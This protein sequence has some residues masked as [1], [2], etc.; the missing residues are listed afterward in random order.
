DRNGEFN[1][2]S[3]ATATKKITQLTKFEDFPII[4]STHGNGNIIFEQAGYLHTFGPAAASSKKLTI[5]IAADL[6]EL[7]PRYLEGSKYIRSADISPSG[8]RVVFD[9]RG[10]IMTVPAEKGDA[11]NLTLTTGTHEKYPAWSADG[12]SI[13][14]FS[15]ATGEYRLHVEAQDGKGEMETYD[16]AGNG[17]YAAIRWS[18]NGKKISY[19]DN[20][21]NL[22]LLDIKSG[23]IAKVD[24]DDLYIPGPFRN[25]FGDWSPDSKWIVYTKITVTN[26][27][28]I[29]LYSLEQAKSFPLTDG[30]SNASDPIFDPNG[31]YIYFLASTDAGPVVDWFAQSNKDMEMNSSIYLVTLTKDLLSPFAKESDEEGD[32]DEDEDDE[33]KGKGEKVK[34]VEPTKIDIDGI[35]NRIIDIPLKAG[36]YSTLGINKKRQLLY[37]VQAKKGDPGKLHKYDLKKRKDSEVMPLDFYIIAKGG[38]KMLYRKKDT[39]GITEAGEKPEDGKGVLKTKELKIKIEPLAEW[40][41]IYDEAWRINRDYFY[42][43]G[44]HGADWKA[45]KAKYSVFLPDLTCRRDLSKL[46]QWMCSE[47]GVGHHRTWGGERVNDAPK[48]SGGLLGT[49][50]KITSGRYQFSKIYGG[51]NWTPNLR[52]P[53]TEPGI[54]AEDGDYLLAV[55]GVDV[56]ADKN[57]YSY[58]ENTAGKIVELTIGARPDCTGSRVV[59]VVPTEYEDAL[60]NRDWVEGNMR[61]VHEATDGQVAYVYVPNT[62]GAGHQYFKRYFFPQQDKKAIIIDE[63]FNGGGLLA[64]YYIDI[65]LR[66]YQSYWNFRYGQDVKTPTASIQGPKVMIIDETAGSG[67]D[68]LPYMF[69]KFE[70]GTLVG[71][72]TWGGLV[73]ILG[74]PLF[75][76]GGSVTAPNVAIWT[77]DGYIVENVGVPPDI[78]VDQTPSEVIKGK[79]PQLEKAIEI[80]LKQ[81]KENPQTKPK[82]PNYPIRGNR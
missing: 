46:I 81:L 66:P 25:S 35:Q 16:L 27:K 74:F 29:Y 37:I 42:D 75:I 70:V 24:A 56:K 14:Y 22:Y 63:R 21:R 6:L 82:R 50:Y 61:K 2:F 23:A 80:A 40:P 52:S 51:L 31:K 73:G 20:A 28:R 43:P 77:K 57:I 3:Y 55:N 54:N 41:H 30:L 7:R 12:K 76:D 53:L 4:G 11:R 45:M 58:F 36:M 79:D 64:D 18:P 5:G 47:L 72:R 71:K 49:D 15:D 9:F 48:I 59:S 69:R 44:M 78:E 10:D 38:E 13:A 60:R 33:K 8:A 65:L 67:G 39:W 17:F 68:M 26:F 19:V 62:A 1:L 34:I 32:V